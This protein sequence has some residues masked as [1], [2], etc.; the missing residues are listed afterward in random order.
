MMTNVTFSLPDKTVRR[1]RKRVADSGGR[2]GAISQI[3][4]DALTSYLDAFD[5]HRVKENFVA[6]KGDEV[7]A[8]ADSLEG[9]AELLR[10]KGIDWRRVLITSNPPPPTVVHLGFR[11]R[12]S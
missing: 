8:E 5:R 9:L 10:S 3:V 7:V 4:D 2:K 12:Q 6:K 11:V 1:L